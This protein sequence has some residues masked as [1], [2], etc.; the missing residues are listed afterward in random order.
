MTAASLRKSAAAMALALAAACAHGASDPQRGAGIP[1]LIYHEIVTDP[2]RTPGETVIALDRFEEQ[3]R[4][5]ARDGWR[6]LSIDELVAVMRRDR[7][8]P[9]KAVVL[10]FDDGWK[11][12]LNAVPVL[13]RHRMRASFWIITGAGIGNDYLEWSDVERLARHPRFEIGSHTVSHP[14]AA[15]DNLVRW[16]SGS[17]P[18]KDRAAVR[19][20]L[21]DSKATLEAKTGRR[22]DYLAWPVG[23]YTDEMVE[24]AK[25]VG[26][27]ALLTAED[28]GN[29]PGGDVLRI[30]RVFVDGAC[31]LA[32]FRRLLV[33]PAYRP[34][35]TSGRATFGHTPPED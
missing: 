13:E 16:M 10:T 23:W 21:A 5:L 9:A 31:D 32:S 28:G 33:E 1:V 4:L 17:T 8:A 19:A 30:R 11:N 29:A 6:T 18:G 15:K 34:C 20:E 26:Y 24:L 12:V 22:I 35:Q 25:E 14:W 2:T 27:R 3:M 7:P